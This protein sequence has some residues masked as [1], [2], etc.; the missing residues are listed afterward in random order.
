MEFASYEDLVEN[1]RFF[2]NKNR[3]GFKQGAVAEMGGF[4]EKEFSNMLNGRKKIRPQDIPRIAE[5]VDATPNELLTKR[6]APS[7]KQDVS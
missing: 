5:A 2:M 4:G 3:H 1:I 6:K 7:A